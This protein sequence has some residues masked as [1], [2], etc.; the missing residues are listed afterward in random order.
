[1]FNLFYCNRSYF[2]VASH[3]PS[4]FHGSID[5]YDVASPDG[6]GSTNSAGPSFSPACIPVTIRPVD[7]ESQRLADVFEVLASAR[8]FRF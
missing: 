2:F 7:R 6:E 3:A 5:Q 4:C 1:V 8:G